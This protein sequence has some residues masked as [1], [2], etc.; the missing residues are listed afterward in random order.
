MQQAKEIELN[1]YNKD[2]PR[3]NSYEGKKYKFGEIEQRNLYEEEEL[4]DIFPSIE[5]SS[6]LTDPSSRQGSCLFDPEDRP[7]DRKTRRQTAATC[8]ED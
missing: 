6:I 8:C 5:D 3:W 4:D 2:T 7:S 1:R